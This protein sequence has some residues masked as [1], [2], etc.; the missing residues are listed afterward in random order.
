[1][2]WQRAE[3]YRKSHCQLSSMTQPRHPAGKVLTGAMG[4]GYDGFLEALRKRGNADLLAIG[5]ARCRGIKRLVFGSIADEMTGR[6]GD[7]ST[8]FFTHSRRRTGVR[9]INR[10]YDRGLMRLRQLGD[11]LD[12]PRSSISPPIFNAV[13]LGPRPPFIAALVS[14]APSIGAVQRNEPHS[15]AS[16]PCRAS[17]AATDI[18]N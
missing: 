4:R 12:T 2:R 6:A 3:G 13:R 9:R 7:I 11:G 5:D 17:F 18:V 14:T 15:S 16:V 10:I 8:G 1:M